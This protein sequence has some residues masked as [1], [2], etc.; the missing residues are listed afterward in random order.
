MPSRDLDFNIIIDD[1]NEGMSPLAHI[2]SDTFYGNSG[3]ASSMVA[4]VISKPKFLTQSPDLSD[5]TNG[6][7]AGVVD[8]LI[9][10]ILDK[11]TD[12]DTTYAIGTTKL[13]KLSSTAV[14]DGGSPSFPQTISGMTSGESLIR[15][16]ANLYGFYNKASGGDIL[17]MPLSSETVDSTWGSTSD[18][19]LES[20]PHPCAAKE[21][22][23]VFGN[24]RYLGVYIEGSSTLDVQKLDFGEGAEVVDVVFNSN[25][26][27]IAVNSGEGKRSQIYLYDGSA[28]SNLLSD[29]AGVGDQQIGFL[30][31]KD[32]I[33]YVCYEDIT[34]D[35]YIIGY[36]DGRQ[37]K[38]IR[39]FS[40]SLP[41]H[42]QKALYKNNIIFA[43]SG[44][45]LASGAIIDQLEYQISTL[46]DGGHDTIGAVAS[47]FGTP[48]VSSTDGSTNHRVAKFSGYSTSSSWSSKLFDTTSG[49]YL[50]KVHTVIVRTKPLHADASASIVLKGDHD[51]ETSNTL[52][53]EGENKSRHIFKTINLP[54]VEDLRV[55][56]SWSGGDATNDCPIRSIEVECGYTER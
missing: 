11:P 20:A 23:M 4:D 3:Q 6:N 9:R 21:D 40:G 33:I 19:A 30:Y 43:S 45:I 12:S 18:A 16:K 51:S 1:F 36:I 26:F 55:E 28:L 15:L 42:R 2:D 52:T 48:L 31:V 39:Y 27:W 41:N 5:L 22:I 35:G 38:P 25:V 24:G 47:P 13:F 54:S 46:A 56:V 7:Q 10:F 32:A 53:V 29:E 49:K 17:K 44:N 8:Q 14:Q 50:A 37:V 34:S